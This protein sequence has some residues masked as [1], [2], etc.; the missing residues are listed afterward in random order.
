M[1]GMAT[2][3]SIQPMEKGQNEKK[4]TQTEQKV[5]AFDAAGFLMSVSNLIFV[6]S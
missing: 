1:V 3:W 4:L 5:N 6:I 2:K